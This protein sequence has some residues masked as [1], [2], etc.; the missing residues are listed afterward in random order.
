MQKP[1]FYKQQ[2]ERASS[3]NSQP[4]YITKVTSTHTSLRLFIWSMRLVNS[5]VDVR[6]L[7]WLMACIRLA[8]VFSFSVLATD[9][10]CIT[11]C[12]SS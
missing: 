5:G 2:Q 6:L 9:T 4:L 1:T 8:S 3:F 12:T 10:A 11:S 7:A